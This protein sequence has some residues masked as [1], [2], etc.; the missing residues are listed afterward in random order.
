MK[1]RHHFVPQFYLRKFATL[2][3]SEKIWTFDV[4]AGSSREST[5][6]NTAYEKYLYSVT[7]EDGA[8]M[9]DLENVISKIEGIAAP[10]LDRVISGER[11]VGEEREAFS[12]FLAL[13]FVRTDSFRHQFAQITM[14][15][16]Q[17]QM[18]ATASHKEAFKEHIKEYQKDTGHKMSEKE[19]ED[20]RKELLKPQN[21][22]ISV[23][24]E[25]TLQALSFHERLIPIIRDM[26]WT[27]LKTKKSDYF[28]TSDNPLTYGVPKIHAHPFYG[29]GLLHEKVELTFPLSAETCL[30]ATWNE[31]PISIVEIDSAMVKYLNRL[32]AIHARR[33]LFGPRYDSG[34]EKLGA[35]YKDAKHGVEISGLG[36]EGFSPI[37]LRRSRKKLNS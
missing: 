7:L 23:D 6:E 28:I 29:G 8:R 35:K 22:T 30:L 21:F 37:T 24:K 26:E 10:L 17:M 3:P 33:F 19:A 18:Y 1:K 25:W 12:S 31:K 5:V 34:I 15:G 36:P 4:E 27:T 2:E 9:D 16:M 14:S 13:M 32:R 20:V 11:L